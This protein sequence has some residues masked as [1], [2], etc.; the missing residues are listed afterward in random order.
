MCGDSP[1][2]YLETRTIFL[3]TCFPTPEASE[4]HPLCHPK[5]NDRTDGHERDI[6]RKVRQGIASGRLSKSDAQ[7]IETILRSS[8]A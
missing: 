5:G 4:T 2:L 7:R 8:E 3:R 1:E 6:Y